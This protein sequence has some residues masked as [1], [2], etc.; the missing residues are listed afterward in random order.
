MQK[1]NNL[2]AIKIN[3][4]QNTLL[5]IG[6]FSII[7]LFAGL[8]SAYIVSKGA[9]GSNWDSIALPKAFYLSTIMISGSGVWGYLS[10]KYCKCDNFIMISRALGITIF[11]GLL[12]AFFQFLGWKS[13]INT[14][15]FLSG[16]NVA[17][18]YLYIL[19]LTHLAHL[20]GGLIALLVVYIRSLSQ[21]YNANNF[22]GLK[23]AIRFWHFLGV[24]WLYLFLFLLLIN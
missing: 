24:L 23:L 16:N 14:G 3:N 5:M 20:V 21:K 18:S 13:L 19:T 4:A 10:L 15:K 11:L 22:H 17:S 2:E 12:F 1:N 6:M 9:L 7:M 8:T